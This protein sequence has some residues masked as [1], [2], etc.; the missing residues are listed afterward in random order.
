MPGTGP[1]QAGPAS[2]SNPSKKNFRIIPMPYPKK[3]IALSTV[4]KA[5]RPKDF[6]RFSRTAAQ[7]TTKYMSS[8]SAE[9][10][11]KANGIVR[12]YQRCLG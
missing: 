8:G 4:G 12:L 10:R 6:F 3:T 11:K 1:A 9:N 7:C 2:N 5:A